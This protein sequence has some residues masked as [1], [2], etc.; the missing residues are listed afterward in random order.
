MRIV[1]WQT[2]LMKYHTFFFWKLEKMS[3]NSSSAAVV[4]KGQTTSKNL[5]PGYVFWGEDHKWME[6]V[7]EGQ[8]GDSLNLLVNNQIILQK[9]SKL[10]I[11]K[12]I[13]KKEK[14]LGKII[15]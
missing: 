5:N 4:I 7:G 12:R 9:I 13:W 8:Q 3:Q 11:S 6:R 15:S 14:K 10:G 1:C 2:I